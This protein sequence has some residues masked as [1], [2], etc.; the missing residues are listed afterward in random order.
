MVFPNW[1]D[2]LA[3]RERGPVGFDPQ[4]FTGPFLWFLAFAQTLLPLAVLE[5]YLRARDGASAIAKLA[6][7]SCL[8]LSIGIT[9]TGIFAATMIL[10]FP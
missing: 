6:A 9:A 4:T 10:W 7:A 1:F 2:V 8:F 5:L 3:F